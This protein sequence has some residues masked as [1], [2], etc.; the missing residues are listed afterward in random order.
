MNS[1]KLWKITCSASPKEKSRNSSPTLIS[2]EVDWLNSMNSLELSEAQWTPPERRLFSKPS[3][4]WIK[5]A[6]AG[7]ISTILE[8]FTMQQS[9]QMFFKGK[10][11]RTKFW[12]NSL[13]LLKLLIQW[14]IIRPQ[15]TSSPRRS[16]K[17]TTTISLPPS[18]MMHISQPWWTKPGNWLMNLDKAKEPKDGPCN[19]EPPNKVNSPAIF[20]EEALAQ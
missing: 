19:L 6:V 18:R 8:V 12:A 11:P 7:S 2:T 5:M 16:S 10:K 1:P 4:S 3:K 9:I 14:E 13:K 15:T 20:S 17:S